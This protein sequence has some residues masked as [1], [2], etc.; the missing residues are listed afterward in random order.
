[1]NRKNFGV[2]SGVIID[3]CSEHGYWFDSSELDLILRWIQTGREEQVQRLLK[4]KE[5][6][7]RRAARVKKMV[8]PTEVSWDADRRPQIPILEVLDYLVGLF[9]K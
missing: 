6:Q 5:S 1:M 4:E 8:S 9:R 3:I 7:T 2:K